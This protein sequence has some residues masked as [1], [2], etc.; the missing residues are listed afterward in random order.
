M[1]SR[2]QPHKR[3]IATTLHLA[4][5][6]ARRHFIAVGGGEGQVVEGHFLEGGLAGPFEGF[7]PGVVAEPVADEVCVALLLKK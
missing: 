7:G 2:M 1:P 3:E 4:D 5:L 6:G